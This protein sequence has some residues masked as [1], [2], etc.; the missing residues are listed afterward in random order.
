M[1]FRDV[2]DPDEKRREIVWIA[3]SF[4]VI[5]ATWLAVVLVF[6]YQPLARGMSYDETV[7]LVGLGLLMFCLVLYLGAREREERVSNRVLV[8]RLRGTVASLDR[9]LE[10]LGELSATSARLAGSLDVDDISRS[11]VESL[12][13]GIRARTASLVLIDAKTGDQVHAYHAPEFGG[14]GGAD[15]LDRHTLWTELARNQPS[16]DTGTAFGPTA[17]SSAQVLIH[18]PLR[19]SNGLIGVLGASRDGSD[20]GFSTDEA[21][22]LT[23]LANMAS[24]AIESAYLH[25]ELRGN[26]LATISSLA[27]S[28]DARD[29][30]TA[31]HAHRVAA[32][33]VR[34]AEHL[35]LSEDAI[36]DI[37]VFGPLHD[38]GKIGISDSILLKTGPLSEAEQSVCREHTLIG[39]RILRPLKPSQAALAMVRNHHEAWDGT[40]YPDGLAGE[41]IH[42]L[43]RILQV[44]DSFDA[45]IC[46]RPYQ[47]AMSEQEV[48]AHF[49]QHAGKHYDPAVVRALRAVARI[50]NERHLSGRAE[51]SPA[52]GS[53]PDDERSPFVRAGAA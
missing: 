15:R 47:A 29:N 38:V 40:G 46:D 14:P 48:L 21:Q 36:A 33:A 42:L 51:P 31:A 26:Y 7:L 39:E 19:V 44:A 35:G 2:G 52:A 11:V 30:Y 12:L 25:A 4:I 43:A 18:A 9:R 50:G 37:E 41:E 16:A 6:G 24:N 13:T 5:L 3:I 34:I 20:K 22:L 8:A 49:Q 10:Q 1:P 32:L 23:T 45:M 53:R 17:K 27:N 28:L